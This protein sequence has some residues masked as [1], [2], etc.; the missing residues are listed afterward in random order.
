[1]Y[2]K[3]TKVTTD[4]KIQ[5]ITQCDQSEDDQTPCAVAVSKKIQIKEE[6]RY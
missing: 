6:E 5:H 1:M 2:F 3:S 4:W